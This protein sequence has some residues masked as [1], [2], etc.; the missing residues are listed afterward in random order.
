[1]PELQRRDRD[2]RARV[3]AGFILKGTSLTEWCRA[4]GVDQGWASNILKAAP[5]GTRA[6]TLRR[7]MMTD[8]GAYALA[9]AASPD[10]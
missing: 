2:V 8:S 5:R 10:A 3:R 6:R 1:M 4:N 9:Q 7:R